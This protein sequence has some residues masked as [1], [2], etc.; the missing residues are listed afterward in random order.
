MNVQFYHVNKCV[1]VCYPHFPPPPSEKKVSTNMQYRKTNR[2]VFL[3][4]DVVGGHHGK[5][6]SFPIFHV[7]IH[8]E[9]SVLKKN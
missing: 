3:R 7:L 9:L 1:C 8:V 6:S 2:D 4:I 5:F